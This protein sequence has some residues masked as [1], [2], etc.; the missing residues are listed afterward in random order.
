M[1]LREFPEGPHHEDH[2][3]GQ[4]QSTGYTMREFEDLLELSESRNH[5]AIAKR[6]VTATAVSR[7]TRTHER[8][9]CDDEQV[10]SQQTPGEFCKW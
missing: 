7:E 3:E 2:D 4:D 1:T 8:P 9:P 5:L 10:V 6:P